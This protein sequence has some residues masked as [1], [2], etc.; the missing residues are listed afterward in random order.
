LPF[1]LC[2]LKGGKRRRRI[3]QHTTID[4]GKRAREVS[5]SSS[6]LSIFMVLVKRPEREKEEMKEIFF[7][8]IIIFTILHGWLIGRTTLRE[9]YADLERKRKPQKRK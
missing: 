3:P 7:F 4:F 8:I 6:S 9:G 1:P 5:S 2:F